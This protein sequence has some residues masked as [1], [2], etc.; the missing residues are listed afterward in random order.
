[1]LRY[2]HPDVAPLSSSHNAAVGSIYSS[3]IP[4]NID[5]GLGVNEPTTRKSASGELSLIPCTISVILSTKSSAEILVFRAAFYNKIGKFL[6]YIFVVEP[7]VGDIR[8]ASV[9]LHRDRV[10]FYSIIPLSVFFLQGIVAYENYSVRLV[11]EITRR[12]LRIAVTYRR[13]DL[14]VYDGISA[15]FILPERS[16]NLF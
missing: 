14:I 11:C 12:R 10:A 15:L 2:A 4:E 7:F 9:R 5:F 6:G 16:D 3:W 1:M 13:D 8:H